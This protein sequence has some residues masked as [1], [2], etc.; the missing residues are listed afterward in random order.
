MSATGIAIGRIGAVRVGPARPYTRPGSFSA[1][2]KQPAQGAVAVGTLG[3]A[4]DEQGDPRVHGGADKAV[5]CYAQAHYPA[6]QAEWPGVAAFQPGAFGENFSVEGADD[7][8]DE[9]H[10]CIGDEWQIGSARF[11]ISQGRQPCWKLNDRF[12][13][14]DM[15]RRVQDSLRAGWY[16]RV[17]ETGHVQ[18]GDAIHLLARPCPGWTVARLLMLIRDRDC[19]PAQMQQVLQLPLPASWQRLFA[20]RLEQGQTENWT[21][22]LQGPE[23]DRP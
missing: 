6:W 20:R 16:L 7:A 21:A 10:V 18:A 8:L 22:R 5:H 12:G 17:L 2:D 3:L 11:A 23:T 13:I 4:G 15:A 1:I 9:H 19:T 14:P